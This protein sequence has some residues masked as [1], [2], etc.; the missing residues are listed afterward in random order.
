MRASVA[1]VVDSGV[2]MV[3]VLLDGVGD[4]PNPDLGGKTPLEA[5]QT[6][7][8]DSMARNGSLGDAITVGRGIAPRV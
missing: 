3:Y 4:L 1:R 7:S 6:P 2:R 8:M 5:A